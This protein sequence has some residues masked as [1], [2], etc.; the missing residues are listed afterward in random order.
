MRSTA[1]F[2]R[3]AGRFRTRALRLSR[4]TLHPDRLVLA[5]PPRAVRL[6]T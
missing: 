2:S 5:R 3:A 6:V 1:T 4:A